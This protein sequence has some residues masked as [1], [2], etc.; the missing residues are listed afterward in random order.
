M[1][2]FAAGCAQLPG[3]DSTSKP[4]EA[5]VNTRIVQTDHK[6]LLA[7]V[8]EFP[9]LTAEAQRAEVAHLN[10]AAGNPQSRLMLAMAYGLPNT[11]TRDSARAQALLDELATNRQLDE[12]SQTLA[13]VM[14]DHLGELSKSTQKLKE[15]QKRAEAVQLK[16]D[17]LQKK[18]DDLKN[19]EKTMVDRDQGVRK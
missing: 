17:E 9:K 10:Q 4:G 6:K 1:V 14:R 19:I 5:T 8:R 18:L 12:E 13:A 16:L 11:A 2:L 3:Q 7:F 15:E